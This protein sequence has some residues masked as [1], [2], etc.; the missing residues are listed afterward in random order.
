MVGG[1]VQQSPH[2]TAGDLQP[3]SRWLDACAPNTSLSGT[4]S[5]VALAQAHLLAMI[6]SPAPV[7]GR[8]ACLVLQHVSGSAGQWSGM[9]LRLARRLQVALAPTPRGEHHGADV[10]RFDLPPRQ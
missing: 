8:R 4:I 2:W 1:V 5:A 10:S 6:E 3:R 9:V 7:D